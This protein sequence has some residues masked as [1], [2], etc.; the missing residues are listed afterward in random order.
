M[1]LVFEHWCFYQPMQD[2]WSSELSHPRSR[3]R[4]DWCGCHISQKI[5]MGDERACATTRGDGAPCL[6]DDTKSDVIGDVWQWV[7][8]RWVA[9]NQLGETTDQ[10]IFCSSLIRCFESFAPTSWNTTQ[11]PKKPPILRRP[12]IYNIYKKREREDDESSKFR[13]P[14]GY[15]SNL[16]WEWLDIW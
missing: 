6:A 7:D 1:L 11:P 10:H 2:A 13:A 12:S 8:H 4:D 15:W 3:T 14:L 9:S 5:P 16:E